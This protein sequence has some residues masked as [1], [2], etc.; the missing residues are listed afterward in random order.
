M[1]YKDYYQILGI[2]KN[3][4]QDDI[5]KAYRKLAKKFH[6]D[7]NPGNSKAE[8]K[9]KEINEA[10][11]VLGNEEKRK[12]YDTF[13]QNYDFRDGS[14]FDPSQFGFGKNVR[15]EYNTGGK[16]GFSDFFN[17]FFRGD[18]F[19][20]DDIF[21]RAGRSTGFTNGFASS[22]EDNIA[23][24][25]ITPEEGFRGDEK[26]IALQGNGGAK[27]ISLRVPPGIRQGEKIKLAGQGNPGT[28]G[29]RRGDLYLKVSFKHGGKYDVDGLNLQTVIDLTPW[30]A[31]LGAE[32]SFDTI[33]GRIIV[34]VPAGIQ[35]DSKIRIAGKGYRDRNGRRG[36]LYIKA[37][38]VN[39][40]VLTRE[41]KSLYEKLKEVST[42]KPGR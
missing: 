12:K 10:Y 31:A 34:K 42:F 39:P 25:E 36:D 38:I 15:H 27:T 16:N 21:G 28:N 8:E 18:G 20:F 32:V 37:K 5:K 22:G 1:Q 19:N 7:A 23:E 40:P 13:G 24:I 2:N 17:M 6:P 29:G 3:A 33:D 9:F 30:E 35:T 4:S 26:R 41:E 11:E 14:D